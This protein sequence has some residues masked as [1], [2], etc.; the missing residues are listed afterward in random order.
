[1]ATRM[2]ERERE[3]ATMPKVKQKQSGAV[4][5]DVLIIGAGPTGLACAIECQKAGIS[6]EVV[7][8]G[9]VVNSIF[10]YPPGM[11]FFTTPELLEIGDI[12]FTTANQKPS[13]EEALVYYRNVAARYKLKIHQYERVV[14][15]AGKDGAF[16]VTALDQYNGM[17][18]Y[19]P[20]KIV[21]ST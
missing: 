3:V 15:V 14:S 7:D 4:K 12:P 8:K 10:N 18:E 11:I 9:C 21:V 17:H 2:K 1:M 5:C 19:K 13:R 20:K 6:V 16:Q